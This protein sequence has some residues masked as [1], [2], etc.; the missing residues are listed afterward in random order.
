LN[1]QLIKDVGT[2][3]FEKKKSVRAI[4]ADL[5]IGKSTVSRYLALINP[6]LPTLMYS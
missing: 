4:A 2:S 3:Y 1:I 5:G 6:N